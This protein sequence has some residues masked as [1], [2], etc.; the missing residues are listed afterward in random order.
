MILP[1]LLRSI[2]PRHALDD[3]RPARVLGDELAEVVDDVVDDDPDAGVVGLAVVRA[4]FLRGERLR[5]L[6]LLRLGSVEFGDLLLYLGEIA[7]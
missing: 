4:D 6:C 3:A 2:P 5:H 1:K 7:G